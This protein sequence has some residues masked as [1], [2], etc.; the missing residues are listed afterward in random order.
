MKIDNFCSGIFD[1]SSVLRIFTAKNYSELELVNPRLLADLAC[2][3]SKLGIKKIGLSSAIRS[4]EKLTQAGHI[5]RHASGMA[6]DIVSLN[7]L[8]VTSAD[9]KKLADRLVN[10]LVQIGYALNRENGNKK[11]VLWQSKHHF[12]HIHV[13][14]ID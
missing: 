12:D 3:G 11:S 5:S 6:V 9:G 7:D 2:F 4:A 10:T 14:R 1:L 13:S 8:P